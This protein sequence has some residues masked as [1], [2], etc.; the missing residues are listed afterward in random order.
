MSYGIAIWNFVE[1]GI[2]LPDLMD[3]FQGFGFDTISFSAWQLL[4]VPEEGREAAQALQELGL[5][6]T[7]HASFDL[8]GDDARRISDLLGPDLLTLTFDAAMSEE[9]RGRFFDA[10]RMVKLL[11]E[12]G[13]ILEPIGTRYGVEDFPLDALALDYY[14]DDLAPLLERP[15]YGMLVDLGHL[16]MRVTAQPYFHRLGVAEYILGL[17]LPILE[18]HV[19]DNHGDRDSHAHLGFGSGD[20]ETMAA[21]LRDKGFAGVSTIEIAPTFHGSTPA[22]DRPRAQESLKLWRNLLEAKP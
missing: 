10:A 15:G 11:V 6:A 7:V 18:V 19:H 20:F 17:P 4:R 2:R 13:V 21:A 16:N 14:R 9:S 5:R 8:T 12:V 3:D 1:E 22:E